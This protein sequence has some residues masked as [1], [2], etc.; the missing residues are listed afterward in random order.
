MVGEGKIDYPFLPSSK[1]FVK[2]DLTK[3]KKKLVQIIGKAIVKY[4]FLPILKGR[5]SVVE[6]KISPKN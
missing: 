6:L 3:N 2:L 5:P 4:P 1:K